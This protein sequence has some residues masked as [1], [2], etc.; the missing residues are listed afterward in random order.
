MDDDVT[1]T[2]CGKWT[3]QRTTPAIEAEFL[4]QESNH[5]AGSIAICAAMWTIRRVEAEKSAS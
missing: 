3:I 1:V 4:L 5:T 2:S